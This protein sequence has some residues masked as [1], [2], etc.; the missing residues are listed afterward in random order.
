MGDTSSLQDGSQVLVDIGAGVTNIIV[1]QG[2]I[3]TFVRILVMGGDSLTMALTS[4][5]SIEREEA[6][7]AS[8]S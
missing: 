2:G 7:A 3:P 1:H 4:G 8:A 6:E 5:L